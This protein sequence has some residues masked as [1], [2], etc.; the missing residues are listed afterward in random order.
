[1]VRKYSTLRTRFVQSKLVAKTNFFKVTAQNPA[2][3]PGQPASIF[4]PIADLVAAD[5]SASLLNSGF[6]AGQ[7][8]PA[9]STLL[10]ETL[11]TT[12]ESLRS[13]VNYLLSLPLPVGEKNRLLLKYWAMECRLEALRLLIDEALENGVACGAGLGEDGV[14]LSCFD[15]SSFGLTGVDLS[16]IDLS[17]LDLSGLDWADA[18]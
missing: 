15:L 6:N 11:P 2:L 1:M 16:G 3:N 18:F 13:H 12:M 14:D 9:L 8:T 5:S 17:G 4:E 7:S 10:N